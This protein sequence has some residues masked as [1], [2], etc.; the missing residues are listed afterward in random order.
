MISKLHYITQGD[1]A[2]QHLEYI[3]NACSSGADWIQLRMKNFDEAVVG[4]A[5]VG[6]Y[7]LVQFTGKL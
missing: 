2:E 4:I 7:W 1:T 5:L 6:K 3:Q